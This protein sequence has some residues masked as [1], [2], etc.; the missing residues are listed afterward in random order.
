MEQKLE[1]ITMHELEHRYLPPNV[2]RA[3]PKV[4]ISAKEVGVEFVLERLEIDGVHVR[5]HVQGLFLAIFVFAS[6]TA[7]VA[8]GIS[9]L[10]AGH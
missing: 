2:R 3:L 5:F 8:A 6:L 1:Q 9:M 7:A 10:V 4:E